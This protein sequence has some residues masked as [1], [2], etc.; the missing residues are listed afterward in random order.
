MERYDEVAETAV[1]ERDL[2]RVSGRVKW[3]DPGKGYG[4]L[5][6]DEPASAGDVLVHITC[7]RAAGQGEPPEGATVI[8]DAVKRAKGLQA[9]K[10]IEVDVSTAAPAPPRRVRPRPAADAGP[11]EPAVVKWFNRTKGYGF[12]TRPE[13]EG[14]VFIHIETLRQAGLDD[15]EPGLKLKVRCGEGPKGPLVVA[16]ALESDEET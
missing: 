11:Y 14:D 7:L 15:A 16:A 6:A 10:I 3:F 5:A 8:C 13:H 9:F 1:D 4:F 12:V 2:V